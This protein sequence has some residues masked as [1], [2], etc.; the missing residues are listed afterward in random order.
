MSAAILI[1]FGF[2][3]AWE[4]RKFPIGSVQRPGPGFVPILLVL[5]VAVAGI[6]IVA[7]G[8][9]SPKIG[10]IEWPGWRHATAILSVC[11]FMPCLSP[12]NLAR[13]IRLEMGIAIGDNKRG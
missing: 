10:S 7:Y 8:G 4:S 2:V 3:I 13:L 5:G 9:S 1:L 6:I 12:S 11:V